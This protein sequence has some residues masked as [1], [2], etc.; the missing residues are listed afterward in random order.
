MKVYVIMGLSMGMKVF[1]ADQLDHRIDFMTIYGHPF[2]WR[3]LS[4][5]VWWHRFSYSHGI[6]LSFNRGLSDEYMEQGGNCVWS[7]YRR[8]SYL[9][10]LGV[11]VIGFRRM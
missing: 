11:G 1:G 4:S 6:V 8:I 5:G 3:Y 2:K 9:L 7:D 10:F